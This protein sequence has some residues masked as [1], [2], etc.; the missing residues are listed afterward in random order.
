MFI[1]GPINNNTPQF[2]LSSKQQRRNTQQRREI[3]EGCR[4]TAAWSVVDEVLLLQVG[5]GLDL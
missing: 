2:Q 1:D 4:S 3:R 5:L